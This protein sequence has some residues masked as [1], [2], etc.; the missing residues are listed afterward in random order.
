MARDKTLI[1]KSASIFRRDVFMALDD[2]LVLLEYDA[3]RDRVRRIYY[4]GVESVAAWQR[5]PLGRMLL[6]ALLFG[7]PAFLIMLSGLEHSHAIGGALLTVM[8]FIELYYLWCGKT[9]FQVVRYGEPYRFETI[10]RPG[11]VQK[12][13]QILDDNILRIQSLMREENPQVSEDS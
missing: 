11:K 9:F 10:A 7:I 4:D 1:M 6:F 3:Y 2:C 13:R 5:W 12:F 8:F